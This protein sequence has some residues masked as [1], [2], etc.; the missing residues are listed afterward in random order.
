MYVEPRNQINRLYMCMKWL[1]HTFPPAQTSVIDPHFPP[2]TA[3][4]TP[5]QTIPQP[6]LS[7]PPPSDTPLSALLHQGHY[8][9]AATLAATTL[10]S[11]TSSLLPPAQIFSLLYARLACLA[12]TSHDE[13]AAQESLILGDIHSPFYSNP[14]AKTGK[15][16]N[17]LPW[18]LRLL[19]TRLQALG[20][21]DPKRA[22]QGYYDLAGH[23]R[24]QY[25]LSMDPDSRELWRERLRDLGLRTGNALVEMGDVGGARRFLGSL[26]DSTAEG[27]D[28][29]DKGVW[30]AMLCLRMGDVEG[31]RR[32]IE[33]GVAE[34]EEG[35]LDALLMTVEGRNEDAVAA[36]RGLL[37]GKHDVLARHALA[38]CLIYTGELAKVMCLLSFY[39][40]TVC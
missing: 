40:G 32:W 10:T 13:I 30:V 5:I 21:K 9:P 4:K 6:F 14:E 36:W 20:A 2:I 38:V 16:S 8:L 34:R 24:G 17:I 23:A 37:D 25:R 31:A 12:I 15:E 39:W 19:A 28:G 29:V 35:V 7:S 26:A 11:T 18:H 1:L 22:V 27:R 33:H 3:L